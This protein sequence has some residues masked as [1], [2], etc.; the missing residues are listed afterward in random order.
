MIIFHQRRLL[1]D[2]YRNVNPG[3]IILYSWI[4]PYIGCTDEILRYYRNILSPSPKM[5]VVYT[6]QWDEL[7]DEKSQRNIFRMRQAEIIVERVR[8]FPG[9]PPA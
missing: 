9:L 1:Q 7:A 6:V 3:C 2:A 4:F 8:Y 5:I